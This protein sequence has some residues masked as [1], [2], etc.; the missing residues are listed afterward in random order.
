[1]NWLEVL[2][3]QTINGLTRG[4]V[5]ALIALGCTMVYGIVELIN[6]AHGDLFMLGCMLAWTM[7]GAFAAAA[8]PGSAVAILVILAMLIVVPLFCATVNFT[9]DFVI[10]RP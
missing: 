5:F 4:A 2:V 8:A 9:V 7:V 10:Y 1:M 3:Q 6:F